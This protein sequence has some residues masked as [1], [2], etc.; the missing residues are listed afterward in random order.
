MINFRAVTL[1]KIVC[2]IAPLFALSQTYELVP[3]KSS[4][5]WTGYSE[6]GGYSQSGSLRAKE[7]R[8]ELRQEELQSATIIVDMKTLEHENKELKRHLRDEDFFYIK[9]FPTA[10]LIYQQKEGDQFVF[11]IMIRG[12][13]QIISVPVK[14][15]KQAENLI[16]AGTIV[17]D[18]TKFDIKYNSSSYFQD[19][20]NYAIKNDFDLDYEFL[21]RQL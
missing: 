1:F 6:V 21:F 11:E 4:M 7:G 10:E 13:K 2:T 5:S 20:G 16:V 9:K 19:L 12:K 3:E 17:L 15:Q 18:R 14:F 8:L